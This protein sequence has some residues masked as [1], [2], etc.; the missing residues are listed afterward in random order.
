[1]IKSTA[2]DAYI[3]FYTYKDE[4][5]QIGAPFKKSSLDTQQII[6]RKDIISISTNKPKGGVGNWSATLAGT[7]DYE[8][9]LK[10]GSWCMIFLSDQRFSKASTEASENSGLKMV[11]LVKTVRVIESVDSG[12]GTRS[13]RY[14]IGGDDF[15]CLLN[16]QI[17]QNRSLLLSANG[18]GSGS[19]NALQYF[20]TIFVGQ[21]T[22]QDMVELLLKG[23]LGGNAESIQAA[24]QK[25]SAIQGN[26]V[27][28]PSQVASFLND[29]SKSG[30]L[31]DV[32]AMHFQK[33]LVGKLNISPDF[34]SQFS[35]W[36]LIQ[37][38]SHRLLNEV[39][40]ELLPSLNED[41]KTVTLRPGIVLRAIPFS[42]PSKKS[43]TNQP[44]KD[45]AE[46]R[47][48]LNSIS[49]H[50]RHRT[51][52]DI[53]E[54]ADG[55]QLYVSHNISESQIFSLNYGKSDSERFN[56]FY[57]T[58][59][60]ILGISMEGSKMADLIKGSS[61]AELGDQN[62]IARN[63]LRLYIDTSPYLN[64]QDSDIKG[65]NY[66][67]RDL[68][69]QSHLF[70]NGQVTIA[71]T[72]NHIPVGTNIKFSE[73]NWVAH[74]EQVSHSFNV[75]GG[76]KSYRTTISFVRLQNVS[77]EPINLFKTSG[78]DGSGNYV[79]PGS[80]SS[81]GNKGNRGE[82]DE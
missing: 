28:V 47:K 73:R 8:K 41:G 20:N 27:G 9:I 1:M 14:E 46:Y 30:R 77:G 18:E 2:P 12:S 35:V 67:I 78:N 75:S 68:W 7:K 16:S 33:D 53:D 82:F 70:E 45:L 76:Y 54:S 81:H 37:A 23:L 61:V 38:Y 64:A 71:G 11:G 3:I 50:A 4:K 36:S 65:I 21:H 32:M 31:I 43:G 52:A 60:P 34:G 74:V 51:N 56:F 59:N 26:A 15:H 6:I 42:T 40:T 22:P 48:Y 80:S 49:D 29:P 66:I 5:T 79:Y 44:N 62:S 13:L 63:G 10:P 72:S 19:L 39:Y 55:I 25:G 69:S 57:V 17:Y 58:G 24:L